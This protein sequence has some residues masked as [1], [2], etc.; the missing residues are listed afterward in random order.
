MRQFITNLESP[1]A[2]AEEV[3][4]YCKLLQEQ[5]TELL[6]RF[7]VCGVEESQQLVSVQHV[8][9]L[10]FL[11]HFDKPTPIKA[12]FFDRAQQFVP[13]RIIESFQRV[14]SGAPLSLKRTIFTAFQDVFNRH[15]WFEPLSAYF[16]KRY[17]VSV[18]EKIMVV[19][20][21]DCSV[22]NGTFRMTFQIN[23][24]VR[25]RIP[26]FVKKTSQDRA[27]NEMLY[28]YCQK[29]FF[30]FARYA[31][32]PAVLAGTKADDELMLAPTVPGL[33]A[34]V[35]LTNLYQCRHKME[36]DEIKA[37]V[38]EASKVL[39]AAFMKHAALGDLLGR[40][41]RHLNNTLL[42]P[43]IDNNIQDIKPS[44]LSDPPQG[45][46]F[47]KR[48]L[49]EKMSAFSLIAIDFE[50]LLGANNNSWA[51]V[52]IDFGLAEINLL[53]LLP[54]FSIANFKDERLQSQRKTS[55]QFY[56]D[57]YLQQLRQIMADAE[58]ISCEISKIY[59]KHL[60]AD[61]L[62]I[63]NKNMGLMK[64][65]HDYARQVFRRYLLDYRMRMVYR[66]ALGQLRE[67]AQLPN[68]QTLLNQLKETGLSRFLPPEGVRLADS[69]AIIKLQCFRG[70]MSKHDA[71]MLQKTQKLAWEDVVLHI[72]KIAQSFA[73]DI[74][75]QINEAIQ[76]IKQDT[77][78]LLAASHT[79]AVNENQSV[80]D[81]MEEVA[82]HCRAFSH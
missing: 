55:I 44:D 42:A 2:R 22:A 52:D 43:V 5:I 80:Q 61:K 75:Q 30:D 68:N 6:V 32:T 79:F 63:F 41:D 24:P 11:K 14:V 28:F 69:N 65:S 16:H 60:V 51:L 21:Q 33:S 70:V 72:D 40:N 26:L 39:I 12:I 48:V 10:L 4:G 82:T 37:L 66:E 20:I 49:L 9:E 38:V 25:K 53:Q 59:P 7:G 15:G 8:Q 76:F 23:T 36:Y 57:V 74:Y 34:D 50:W 45:L 27:Y 56:F 31:D 71:H 18:D 46:Q 54:E 78:V 67:L 29:R 73:P 3:V 17:Q 62:E 19:D 58:V 77:A 81:S 47:C 13:I 64:S 35:V 1:S